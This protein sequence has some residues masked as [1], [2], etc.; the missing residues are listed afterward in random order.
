M[1]QE[2][3]T[4]KSTN[5]VVVTAGGDAITFED[6]NRMNDAITS[7]ESLHIK[8]F[9]GSSI[10]N[11][12]IHP[13]RGVAGDIV[14]YHVIFTSDWYNDDGEKTESSGA[15][16]IS[17]KMVMFVYRTFSTGDKCLSMILAYKDCGWESIAL[18]T[19]DI[20]IMG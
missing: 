13:I 17:V 3:G 19:G 4:G 14:N 10:E 18:R 16:T 6:V 1:K 5:S 9:F 7:G 8:R 12:E 2:I 15:G 20:V 11:I